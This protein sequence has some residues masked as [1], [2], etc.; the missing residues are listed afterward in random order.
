MSRRHPVL[1]AIA[2]AWWGGLLLAAPAVV[3]QN[4]PAPRESAEEFMGRANKVTLQPSTRFETLTF[5]SDQG[6]PIAPPDHDVVAISD[7]IRQAKLG[8][9]LQSPWLSRFGVVL[10]RLE[11]GVDPA[12]LQAVAGAR[13]ATGRDQAKQ[14]GS[15]VFDAGDA[16]HIIVNQI[17]VQF[18]PDAAPEDIRKLLG[19]YCAR[20]VTQSEPTGRYLLSFDRQTARHALAM[21]NRLNQEKIVLYA[22]PDVIVIGNPEAKGPMAATPVNTCPAAP[23]STGV[24]PYY[25][26]AWHLDH[27]LG[28]PGDP[29]ADINAP[30]A[31]GAGSKGNGVLVAILDDAVEQTHEDLAIQIQ[32]I[33]NAFPNRNTADLQIT[34]LDRHGTAVAGI[35][36]AISQN[37]VGTKG[38]APLAKLMA[39]RVMEWAAASSG[40]PDDAQALYPNS[41]VVRGIEAA[42]AAGARVINMS[43]S[44]GTFNYQTCDV[45]EVCHGA[46]QLAVSAANGLPTAVYPPNPK[47]AVTV[48]PTGNEGCDAQGCKP[49]AFP[50]VL[51]A[52]GMPVIAVGA[53]DTADAV[54]VATGGE[55]GSNQGPQISVVAPGVAVVTTD[56]TGTKGYCPSGNYV[57][58]N[59]TSAASPVVAGVVALMQG[60]YMALGMPLPSSQQIKEQLQET[61]KHFATSSNG[62]DTV[63]GFGRVDAC[64]ALQAGS[65]PVPTPPGGFGTG[66]GTK[67][68]TWMIYSLAILGT[69]LIGWYV[70]RIAARKKPSE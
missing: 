3:A 53:T 47:P 45:N 56:R 49:I 10:V 42:I 34:D 29:A 18:H 35:V 41:A 69:G 60:Q 43:I 70:A 11:A 50:A 22:Q 21:V 19:R 27:S 55:W 15:P 61:A 66:P 58:F 28:Q 25:P 32:Q 48:F 57:S 1:A 16:D 37:A 14:S 68:P 6:T 24:D 26:Q 63:S 46:V 67:F 59:G 62:F 4:C 23:T 8:T 31:W 65:C 7:A 40:N 5:L 44:L 30:D 20:V 17:M 13:V 33:F 54:K 9:V 52:P 64:K 51:S 39:V 12:Q 38:V 36:G 2:V